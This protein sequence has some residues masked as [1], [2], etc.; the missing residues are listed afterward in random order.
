MIVPI[1]LYGSEVWG[2]ENVDII[3]QFQ[4][5]FCKML[6]GLKQSTPNIMIYGELGIIPLNLSIENRILNFWARVVNGKPDKISV[7]LY[8]LAYELHK[9]NIYQSPWITYVKSS[10]DRIGL[11]DNWLSQTV[12]NIYAFKTRVKSVLHDNFTQSWKSKIFESSKCINH[13]IYKD[14]FKFEGYLNL[15]PAFQFS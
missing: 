3:N 6:L 4:L 7:I 10:F 15:L 11:S 14:T 2:C 5:K 8:K 12:N 13:R 1:L 9:K